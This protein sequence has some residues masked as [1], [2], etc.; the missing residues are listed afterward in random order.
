MFTMTNSC[1]NIAD[2]ITPYS[3]RLVCFLAY[4]PMKAFYQRELSRKTKVSVGETNKILKKLTAHSIVTEE[5]RGRTYF[6]RFNMTN[7]LAR[8]MKIMITVS[9]L[10][11]LVEG[12]KLLS[13]KVILFGS[14][15]E[16]TD[17]VESD[18]DLFVLTSEKEKVRMQVNKHARRLERR[19][20]GIIVDP[21]ELSAMKRKDKALYER[22][23]SGTV[24]WQEE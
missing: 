16:G 20:S 9:T 4:N 22:I 3:M 5:K 10:N 15:A 8:Q 11:P 23:R 17:T 21:L 7:A 12:I 19:L 1:S 6:Y 2:L 14:C 18:I 24:L 13:T